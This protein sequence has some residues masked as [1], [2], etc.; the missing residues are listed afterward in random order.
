MARPR[1]SSIDVATTARLLAA[2]EREFGR[3]GFHAARLE[4]IAAA[5]GITRSSLLYHWASKDALYG[6][7]VHA[8]FRRLANALAGAAGVLGAFEERLDALV[9][10]YLSFLEAHPGLP[11][12]LLREVLDGAGPGHELLLREVAPVLEQVE[13]FIR[14]AGRGRLRERLPVRGALMQ[15]AS[16][17]LVRAAAGD[18]AGPLWGEPDRTRELARKLVLKE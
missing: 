2:A 18:L 4:D 12:L 7:V 9:D 3:V 6:A 8:A 1:K 5:A 10:G 14:A 13:R 15:I 17:A 16:S 11:A